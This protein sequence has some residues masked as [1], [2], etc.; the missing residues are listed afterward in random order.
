M[1]KFLLKCLALLLPITATANATVTSNNVKLSQQDFESLIAQKGWDLGLN[2]PVQQKK[3]YKGKPFICKVNYIIDGD[4][5]NC[6]NHRNEKISIR[7]RAVD[8]PELKQPQGGLSRSAL[9]KV[10]PAYSTPTY[11]YVYNHK[12]DSYGRTV[13]F[14]IGAYMKGGWHLTHLTSYLVNNGYVWITPFKGETSQGLDYQVLHQDFD[15][16]KAR[17]K[18]IWAYNDNIEPSLWRKQNK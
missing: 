13:G 3:G 6:T 14:A 5:F 17:K 1:I 11:A 10:L 16:I 8:A 9:Q 4:T 2:D 12:K 18:G 15:K 7:L